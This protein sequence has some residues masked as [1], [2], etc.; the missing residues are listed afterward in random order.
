MSPNFSSRSGQKRSKL[1]VYHTHTHMAF[2]KSV[3]SPGTQGERRSSIT[4]RTAARSLKNGKRSVSG[5]RKQMTIA[6][7]STSPRH[8]PSGQVRAPT[9]VTFDPGYAMQGWA[10][11]G[12]P[13]GRLRPKVPSKAQPYFGLN[14]RLV[15]DLYP[16]I[17]RTEKETTQSSEQTPRRAFKDD[18]HLRTHPCGL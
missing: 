14:S 4:Q 5:K 2:P 7:F 17:N 8:R 12:W 11:T 3:F 1:L 15:V 6:S 9:G 13:A 18:A 16:E 10:R